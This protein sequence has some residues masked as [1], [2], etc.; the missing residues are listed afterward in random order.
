MLIGFS[1]LLIYIQTM[2]EQ[3]M[4]QNKNKFDYN[5]SL[6]KFELS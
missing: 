1:P 3:S 5:I 2:N 6:L 4:K